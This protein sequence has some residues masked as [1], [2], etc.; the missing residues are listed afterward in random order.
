MEREYS[1]FNSNW[2]TINL[3]MFQLQVGVLSCQG[4]F[5]LDVWATKWAAS[6]CRVAFWGKRET[7]F[8]EGGTR[9]SMPLQAK[10][11]P[12]G[13]AQREKRNH[14]HN[15]I[16]Q[17]KWKPSAKNVFSGEDRRHGGGEGVEGQSRQKD[18]KRPC[19]NADARVPK[20]MNAKIIQYVIGV[21]PPPSIQGQ[22][23]WLH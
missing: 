22:H 5:T 1:C 19:V 20:I 14:W 23:R 10:A 2:L 21:P 18:T 6:R 16:L 15:G 9:L 17:Q 7:N 4:D 3:K 11:E 8:H 13:Q 12:K